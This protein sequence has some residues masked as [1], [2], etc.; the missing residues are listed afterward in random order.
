MATT[1][2]LIELIYAAVPDASRWQVFLDTFVRATGCKR[3]TLALNASEAADWMVVCWCG[4]HDD[5]IRL[6]HERYAASDPWAVA[7]NK[8]QEGEIPAPASNSVHER[9]SNKAPPTGNII[10]H[11]ALKVASGES[12]F[13]RTP[14]PLRSPWREGKSRVRA[15]SAR[16]PSCVR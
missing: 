2:D 6:Y 15:E 8:M 7:G 4:W 13:T 1:S 12:F 9:S 11:W 5:Q 10:V 3:G 16:F 14:A